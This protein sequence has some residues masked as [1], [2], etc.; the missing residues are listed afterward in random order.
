M[1]APEFRWI[2]LNITILLHYIIT[3]K[4]YVHVYIWVLLVILSSCAA[5]LCNIVCTRVTDDIATPHKPTVASLTY[6]L[7]LFHVLS[8]AAK[9]LARWKMFCHRN[10]SQIR[11]RH[12]TDASRTSRCSETT[13]TYGWKVLFRHTVSVSCEI[14]CRGTKIIGF[15]NVNEAVARRISVSICHWITVS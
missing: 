4:R 12:D 7:D 9:R 1:K 3:V 2:Y 15:L 13:T 10:L 11:S 6:R 5:I 8:I 14:P